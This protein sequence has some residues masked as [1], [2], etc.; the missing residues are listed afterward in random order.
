MLFLYA[1]TEASTSKATATTGEHEDS[2]SNILLMSRCKTI[3]IHGDGKC[4]FRCLAVGMRRSLQECN[5][6]ADG[7]P[8]DKQQMNEE[9][10][11]ADDMRMKIVGLI[12]ANKESIEELSNDIPFLLENQIGKRR[13]DSIQDRC[14]AMSRPGEYADFLEIIA[15]SYLLCAQI[16]VYLRNNSSAAYTEYANFPQHYSGSRKLYLAYRMDTEK[17][18]GHY[19]FLIP[20]NTLQPIDVHAENKMRSLTSFIE[21]FRLTVGSVREA[22]STCTLPANCANE[23]KADV[24]NSY[25]KYNAHTSP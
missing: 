12:R 22:A 9:A 7:K 24:G 16:C 17:V 21:Y 25:G 23:S 14:C 3:T 8:I 6:T 10:N 2:N 20:D 19:D 13:Y 5:R 1:D 4:F 15:A 11:V 18:D